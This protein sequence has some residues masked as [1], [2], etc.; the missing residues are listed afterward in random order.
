MSIMKR[1]IIFS[2]LLFILLYTSVMSYIR[3]SKFGQLKAVANL[4]KVLNTLEKLKVR[5]YRNQDWCKNIAYQRG[6]FSDN[7]E[8]TTC[9]LFNEK[10][11]LMDKR[12]QQDFQTV[13]RAM[14]E[15]GVEIN[16]LFGKYDASNHLIGAEFDLSTLCRCSYIYEPRYQAFPKNSKGKYTAINSDWF[17]VD[18]N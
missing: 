6:G 9:N 15:T 11:Q 12:A 10:P 1:K 13:A 4:P 2:S 18:E 8:A 7:L 17:F 3:P 16:F 14:A 5:A